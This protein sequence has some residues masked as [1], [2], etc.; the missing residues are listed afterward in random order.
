MGVSLVDA[1]SEKPVGIINDYISLASD[2]LEEKNIEFQLTGF[3]S[4]EEELQALKDNRIDMIFHMNQNPY[5]AEQNDI[6]LSN[7]V[8][9]V[10]IAV[11]TGVKKFD[12]NKEN[13][14][15]VSRN[16][17][18]GKWYI[19]FNYPF[20]EIKEYDS[21]DEV[22][23]AVHSGEADCFVVKAGQSLKT[24][25]DRKMRSIFL[26]KSGTSC[27]AVTRENIILMNILNKTIQTL[28]AS[29]LSSLFSVYENTSGKVTLV[30]YIK[31]NLRVVSISFVSVT[32]VII[33]IIG[34]LMMKARKSQIQAENANAA[35]SDFLFNMS[36]DIRT[37][38]NALLGYSELMKRELTDPKL[39]DYQEKMEQSGN[40][41]LSIINNVLDM[42]RIESGKMELDENY[43][44]ISDIYL[45][46]Y[47]IF[48][49][50]AEKKGIHLELEYDVLHEHVIC[51]ETKNRE[52]F[53]NL[54]SNAIKYTA[55]GG[56]V[57]I[58]I[59]ELD[60][61]RGGYVRIQTQVIDTG[62]GMSEEFLPSLFEAF[63]RERNTTAGKVAGTGLGMP[64]IKKYV[65]MMGGSIEVE[66]KLG[67]GSKFTVIMEYR[68][69]D[70]G[71]YEQDTN[72]SPDTEE[73]DWISG[74][75][76]LLAEDNDLNAEIAE[77]ILEDMGLIVDR[78]EDGIQCVA[79]MEQKPAGT[80]DLILMDIQMPNMDG[81][82][83]TQAIRRLADKKKAGI[84]IIAMTANA[85][86]EDRKKAFEKG[87]NG[88]IAKPVDA[89]KA[90]KTILSV[91]R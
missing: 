13:T 75:H 22:E 23:K 71:Y 21:S 72:P 51:D 61:D 84:P 82:K 76:V 12:E 32:L 41:L 85:F 42:A 19:S 50:E 5:E 11:I 14:V 78:V 40:L 28:P 56:T 48:Q 74:K 29:R 26:T 36:H 54:L 31:D 43:V 90:K 45:G 9:E 15:A 55:S 62:I 59:T 86:E 7:T 68:I 44:K 27:F 79:R 16:N 2:C 49:I 57:T 39:L 66:S 18:L 60:C 58:R 8:F 35:K 1:E 65:D 69:A 89:E 46:V 47:R 38:M 63:A 3:D 77:F 33:L 80:Y 87:M 52:V 17:L 4:Q 67:E 88:H 64:I 20:W 6:I 24:L 37:P 81:Y 53:L 30:E 73:T 34:Y 25:E 91:L 70:K 10:N 83:A